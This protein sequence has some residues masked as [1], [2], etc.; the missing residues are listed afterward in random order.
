MIAGGHDALTSWV[1]VLG[2]SLLGA[3]TKD[4]N[5]DPEHASRPFE[6][7]RTGFVL[8]EGAV[9]LDP[10]G[11]RSRPR[12]RRAHLRGDR[13]LRIEPERLPDD[14]PSARRR[15]RGDRD[16]PGAARVG[17][18]ARGHRLRRRARHRHPRRRHLRDGRH[19]AHLRRA[20]AQARDQLAQVDDRPLHR[21][22]GALNL[23]AAVYASAR[24]RRL[25]HHQPRPRRPRVRPRLR[26][27]TSRASCRCAR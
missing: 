26:A 8:G 27:R 14:R 18:G 2:F 23:L 3:L 15:R 19:Q 17:A 22:A 7:D 1:D 16:E 6:R 12:P 13:R 24:R 4:Y 5:D 20:R 25:A 10:R 9:V 11:A 21:A